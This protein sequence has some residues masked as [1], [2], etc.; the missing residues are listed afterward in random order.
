MIVCAY[1]DLDTTETET[2]IIKTVN[3]GNT[4]NI[5]TY[6]TKK[7]AKSDDKRPTL[8]PFT[9]AFPLFPREG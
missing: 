2:K 1:D 5:R 3:G 8:F 4:D 9:F 7:V 6:S